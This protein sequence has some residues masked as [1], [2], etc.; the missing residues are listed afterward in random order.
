MNEPLPGAR[1]A[2]T[3]PGFGPL[4]YR[5]LALSKALAMAGGL[6]FVVLVAM[7]IVSI[8][9]RKLAAAPVPGD[10]ELLQMSAAFACA[11]FF[12][13]CHLI[14]GD[15][16]VDFF[17]AK[18]SART[19]HA[20]D[21]LGSLLFGLMGA[22]LAWRGT[23]GM[24]AMKDSGE[25]SIILG[26]PIWLAQALMIPGFVLMALAGLYMVGAHLRSP[27]VGAVQEVTP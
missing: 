6:V 2:G 21:A 27:A 4:G 19:I 3:L 1:V 10:V 26:W 17:T 7:S 8:V 11:C 12:A 16:K 5:L 22:A 13:Y 23:A 9:G 25:T 20:L 15:V 24:L 14:G 18:A